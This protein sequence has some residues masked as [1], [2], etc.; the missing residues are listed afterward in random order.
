MKQAMKLLG[1]VVLFFYATS[2]SHAATSSP[3]LHWLTLPNPQMEVDGLPFYLQNGGDLYRLSHKDDSTYP[4][5]V[6]ALAKEPSGA[7]IRF[8]TNS[9]TLAIRLEYPSPPHMANMQPF[10][11]SGVDLYVGNTSWGT[12]IADKDAAPGKVY[13]HVYF[14]FTARPQQARDITLYLP[15]YLG[16]K[17]VGIGVDEAATI[18]RPLPFALPKPLVFYGTSITQGCCA[19]RSGVSYAA[20]LGRLF[21][22]DFVNL[23]FSGAGK[24][25]QSLAK[26][27][28][29]I[30]AAAYILDGSNFETGAELNA[31]LGPFIQTIRSAHPD[32]PILVVSS[33]Y[34]PQET[35]SVT[36]ERNSGEKRDVTRNVVSTFIAHGDHHIQLIEGTDLLGPLETAG[37]TDGIHPNDLGIE[38]M[39]RGYAKRLVTVLN[40]YD[41]PPAADFPAAS[42]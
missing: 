7:R 6:V 35:T 1:V 14:N 13:E 40:L 8:R 26:T 18:E 31:A 10:G 2:F 9:T 32:T 17:V 27:V 42:K 3:S 20:N 4:R 12:A 29:Q 39:T 21:N 34:Y 5:R 19:S 28:A 11:Q 33:P 36:R 15:L 30:D 24:Y 38:W 41:H 16:V 37:T 23:G 25:E 22:L